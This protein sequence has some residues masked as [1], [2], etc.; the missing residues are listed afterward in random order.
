M[1][2]N[3]TATVDICVCEWDHDCD[4][5]KKEGYVSAVGVSNYGPKQ[6]RKIHAYLRCCLVCVCVQQSES[7]SERSIESVREQ[8]RKRECVRERQRER[9]RER[10]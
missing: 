6:L 9:K 5:T 3:G 2:A 10:K 7:A 4:H 1:N 8:K